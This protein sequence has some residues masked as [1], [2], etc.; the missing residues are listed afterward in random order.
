[1][2]NSSLQKRKLFIEETENVDTSN[3]NTTTPKKHSI[4]NIGKIEKE[5]K[6]TDTSSVSTVATTTSEPSC[7]NNS[8]DVSS[9]EKKN[10][11]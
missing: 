10:I 8:D 9:D 7:E 11:F 1:L 5:N 4:L 6:N 2:L 3:N